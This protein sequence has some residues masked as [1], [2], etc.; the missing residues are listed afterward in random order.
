V[1]P[2]RLPRT[3]FYKKLASYNAATWPALQ[4]GVGEAIKKRPD[5]VLKALPAIYRFFQKASSYRPIVEDHRS[6]LRDEIGIISLPRDLA[7][8][9]PAKRVT[10]APALADGR[11]RLKIVA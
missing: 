3:L 5:Y 8:G 4:K 2:T 10:P 11:R 7:N 6:H 9:A 1:L